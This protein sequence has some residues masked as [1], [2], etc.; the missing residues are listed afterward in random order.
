MLS[1]WFLTLTLDTG[2][3]FNYGAGAWTFGSTPGIEASC[4][5]VTVNAT[6]SSAIA[7]IGHYHKAEH[8]ESR[9]VHAFQTGCT[10]DQTVFMRKKKL[11]AMIGG[12]IIMARQN[13]ETGA[14]EEIV[15]YFKAYYN[16][17]YYTN[18]RWSLAGPVTQVPRLK[19]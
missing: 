2:R 13:P 17:G 11:V 1:A 8:L 3:M 4:G 16:R 19:L 10:Q 7:L 6:I 12:W 5:P 18:Q 14:I 15:S 9:N